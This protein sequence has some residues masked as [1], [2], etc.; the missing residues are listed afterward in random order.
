MAGWFGAMT[1]RSLAATF[2]VLSSDACADVVSVARDQIELDTERRR[3]LLPGDSGYPS[4]DQIAAW[5]RDSATAAAIVLAPDGCFSAVLDNARA[6]SA[7]WIED[8][9]VRALRERKQ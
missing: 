9:F 4:A 5:K 3:I 2:I 8:A 7:P 1:I 6:T